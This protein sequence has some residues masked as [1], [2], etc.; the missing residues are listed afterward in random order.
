MMKRNILLGAVFALLLVACQTVP[1]QTGAAPAAAA[2]RSV[3]NAAVC[4][5]QVEVTGSPPRISVDI[6]EL[7]VARGNQGPGGSGVAIQWRLSSND[8]EFRN[9][10]IQ[11]Y[12]SGYS[13]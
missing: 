11:Y 10:S 12:D 7:V 4:Q 5:I 1:G 3:C 9:D 2:K 6:D 13:S 8:Y